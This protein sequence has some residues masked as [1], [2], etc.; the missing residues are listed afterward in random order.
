MKAYECGN[1]SKAL[2]IAEFQKSRMERS[3]QLALAR[4]ETV[5]RLPVP[6]CQPC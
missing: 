1:Y 4:A 3:L 2:E 6:R 5:G